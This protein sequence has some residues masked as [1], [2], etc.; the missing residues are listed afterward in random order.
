[1]PDADA[2][3]PVF[4]LTGFLGSGKTTVLRSILSAPDMADTAVVIN[5]FGEI[6]LDHL[7]V[8]QVEGEAVVLQNGCVCCALRD[9]LKA[10]L[11]GLLDRAAR[12][13]IPRF[14]RIVV[15]TTGLADPVPILHTLI[16]DPMLRHQ[17]RPERTIVTLDAVL[18]A[19]QLARHAESVRQVAVADRIVLTKTDIASE[20]EAGN[21]LL[22]AR[23]VNPGAQVEERGTAGHD[24]HA[25]LAVSERSAEE[26]LREAHAWL[27]AFEAGEHG[28]A[29]HHHDHAGHD[30][31]SDVRS[32]SL[33]IDQRLDWS[34]FGVW[35]SALLHRHGKRI[36]RVKGILDVNDVD[37]PVVLQAVEHLMHP[38]VHLPKW[39]DGV[40]G[41]R[42]VFITRDLDPEL[43]RRSLTVFLGAATRLSESEAAA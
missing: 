37:G 10:T 36:L 19:G 11:Q 22:A 26:R 30:H 38:P 42:L 41:S 31:E 4:L 25:L 6:G 12:G 21:T 35:L 5:E 18:G 20:A 7:I 27:A 24:P 8:G 40:R 34:A 16:A 39:P 13:D 28:Q 32:L 17:V 15:E 3:I 9:D 1:L 14:K 33:R 43:I 23:R 29:H 2:R